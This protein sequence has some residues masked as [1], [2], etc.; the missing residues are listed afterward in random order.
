M[1][2][3]SRSWINDSGESASLSACLPVGHVHFNLLDA[4]VAF[5]VGLRL[6][7]P[8]ADQVAPHRKQLKELKE[9]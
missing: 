8:H 9:E 2:A 7:E 6:G 1:R 4:N 5:G 3:A